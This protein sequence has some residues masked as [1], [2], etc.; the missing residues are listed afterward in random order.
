MDLLWI[1]YGFIRIYTDLN[2]YIHIY[3]YMDLIWLLYGF[4]MYIYIYMDL[5]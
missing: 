4:N 5:Y 1:Q 2:R 3:I